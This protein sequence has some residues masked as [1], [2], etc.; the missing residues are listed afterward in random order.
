MLAGDALRLCC[1]WRL[2]IVPA[3]AADILQAIIVSVFA[4]D[5]ACPCCCWRLCIVPAAAG[6]RYAI[7]VGVFAGVAAILAEF[8]AL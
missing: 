5:A 1:C 4:S 8:L 2:C 3:A 7:I 6:I